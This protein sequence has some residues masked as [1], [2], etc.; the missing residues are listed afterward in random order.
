MS[1]PA[2][3]DRIERPVTVLLI[4]DQPIVAESVRRMLA[5]ETDIV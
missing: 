1:L 5:G 4:D 3:T 2:P